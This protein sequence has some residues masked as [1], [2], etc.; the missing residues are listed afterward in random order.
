MPAPARFSDVSSYI[1][2][3]SSPARETVQQLISLVETQRPGLTPVIA[4][5]VPQLRWGKHYV[6][7]LSVAKAHITLAPWGEGVLDAFRPR[8]TGYTVNKGTFQVPKDWTI[9][10]QLILDMVDARLALLELA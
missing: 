4:W 2:A 10:E 7:G 1:A 3:Q 8:L 5:N 6:F 9:D